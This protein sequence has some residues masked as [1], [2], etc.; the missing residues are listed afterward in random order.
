[1]HTTQLVILGLTASACAV[2][3]GACGSAG[4]NAAATTNPSESALSLSQCMHSHGIKNFP[5]PTS[6]PGGPGLQLATSPGSGTIIADGVKFSGPA[7]QAA[8]NAC[9]KLL[10]GG[11]APPPPLTNQQKQQALEFAACMRKHGV[12]NFPDPTFSPGGGPKL[13]PAGVD[14]SS[15]AFQHAVT[16]CG[17]GGTRIG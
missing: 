8:A 15:P 9:K 6:G 5:D 3:L 17:G 10:P 16:A 12:P 1:M 14:P 2:A 13:R 11:G 4:Y 7:F